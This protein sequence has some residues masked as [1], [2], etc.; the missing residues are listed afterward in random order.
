[1][2]QNLFHF[3]P[4]IGYDLGLSN[5]QFGLYLN[6]FQAQ[7]KCQNKETE[8]ENYLFDVISTKLSYQKHFIFNLSNENNNDNSQG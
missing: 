1:V 2:S 6:G 8:M 5:L 4:W 3:Q 7:R